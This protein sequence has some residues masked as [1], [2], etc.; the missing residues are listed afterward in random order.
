MSTNVEEFTQK[1]INQNIEQRNKLQIPY[2]SLPLSTSLSSES[3]TIHSDSLQTSI[4]P[5]PKKFTFKKN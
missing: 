1:M 2:P 5:P 3:S 4:H